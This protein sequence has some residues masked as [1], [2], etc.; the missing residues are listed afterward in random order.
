MKGAAHVLWLLSSRVYDVLFSTA[1]FFSRLLF[2]RGGGGGW[3]GEGRVCFRW[4]F[5][6]FDEWLSGGDWTLNSF[7]RQGWPCETWFGRLK[8][9]NICWKCLPE[10]VHSPSSFLLLPCLILFLLLL[11][12]VYNGSRIMSRDETLWTVYFALSFCVGF[13]FENWKIFYVLFYWVNRKFFKEC[14]HQDFTGSQ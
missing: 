2:F 6:L 1:I 12:S 7:K 10:I 9:R 5:A 14:P 8:A 11:I 3:G 13:S 4:D